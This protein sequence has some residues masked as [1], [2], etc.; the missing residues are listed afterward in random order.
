M[1]KYTLRQPPVVGSLFPTVGADFDFY[2]YLETEYV[3]LFPS[4]TYHDFFIFANAEIKLWSVHKRIS[5][6]LYKDFD[7]EIEL[8]TYS[9][10]I[11]S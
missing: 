2:I 3:L 10:L 9:L 1:C 6:L 11:L 4:V 7:C 8:R 5:Y